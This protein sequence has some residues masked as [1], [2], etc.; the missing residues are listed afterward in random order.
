[1][2]HLPGINR[3][4]LLSILFIGLLISSCSDKAGKKEL[5]VQSLRQ[6]FENSNTTISVSSLTIL[7]SLEDKTTDFITKERADVWYP[8]AKQVSELTKEI[9][10]E[11]ETLKNNDNPDQQK[12]RQLFTRIIKYK[13]QLLNIDSQIKEVFGKST[14]PL[15][16]SY[17]SNE[18]SSEKFY[19]DYFIAG[20]EYSFAMLAKLQ[21]DIRIVEN[22]VV[23]FCHQQ[24]QVIICGFPTFSAI[25]GQNSKTL[26]PNSELEITAGIGSYSKASQPKITINGK[27]NELNEMGYVLYKTRVPQKPGSYKVPV[28][29]EYYDQV[30][31]KQE[32]KQFNIEYI[33]KDCN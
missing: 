3:T 31:G 8:K 23:A 21:N 2:R 29:I 13:E 32:T 4:Q 19:E 18:I 22:K 25:V 6:S 30:T 5:I 15:T 10:S 9:M 26:D 17:D 24:T 1:M 11:I 7:R 28:I 14:L 16:D 20:D 33:V 27:L 12:L